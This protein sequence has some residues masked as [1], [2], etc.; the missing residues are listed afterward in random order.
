MTVAR[1][2]SDDTI[3]GIPSVYKIGTAAALSSP[4][5]PYNTKFPAATQAMYNQGPK[6]AAL[7]AFLP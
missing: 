2:N 1:C 4:F 6:I 5:K 7:A 3:D